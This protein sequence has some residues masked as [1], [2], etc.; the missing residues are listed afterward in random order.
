MRRI[1]KTMKQC[2]NIK[3]RINLYKDKITHKREKM[4]SLRRRSKDSDGKQK[5]N[6][7]VAKP[8]TE[9]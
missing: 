5:L 1:S 9:N 4:L 8:K 3:L 7:D 6:S 2:A